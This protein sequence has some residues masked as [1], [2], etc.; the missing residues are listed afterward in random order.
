MQHEM[1]L[2]YLTIWSVL[3]VQCENLF[4]K[5]PF[6]YEEW[7]DLAKVNF[8]TK[9][10]WSYVGCMKF[11]QKMGGRSPPVRT[12]E[13]LDAMAGMLIDLRAFPPFSDEYYSPNIFLSVTRG[14]EDDTYGHMTLEHWPKDVRK[15]KDGLWRDYYTGEELENYNETWRKE[16]FGKRSHCATVNVGNSN[17]TLNW[18]TLSCSMMTDGAAFV[19]SCLKQ[20][21]LLL[22]GLCSSSNFRTHYDGGYYYNPQHL[23]DSFDKVFYVTEGSW[24]NDGSSR[25]DYNM[26]ISQWI[27]SST[28]SQTT[29]VSSAEKDTYLIGK[30]N[31]T[32]SNENQQCHL[33]KGK[34][35]ME[36]FTTELKLTGCEQGFQVNGWGEVD[37]NGKDGEFT[38]NNGQC[39]SMVRRC[40]Q[41]PDCDDFSDEKGC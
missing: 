21:P 3:N 16:F 32:V 34:G 31:W 13:E 27:L 18:G 9:K 41:L 8:F 11:C 39:V 15:A 12:R 24:G 35:V 19:C 36:S 23:S 2:S 1:I 25:I 40:D 10:Q 28:G 6:I 33:E 37:E 22:R 17:E 38:C 29:A 7:N 30:H 14:E 5:Q 4:T 20:K 26:T